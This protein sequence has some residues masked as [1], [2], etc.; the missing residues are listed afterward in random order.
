M[1]KNVP[2]LKEAIQMVLFW[3]RP[4]IAE[5]WARYTK[6]P[7]GIKGNLTTSSFGLDVYDNFL[8]TIENKYGGKKVHPVTNSY[9]FGEKNNDLPLRVIEVLE[10]KMTASQAINEFKQKAKF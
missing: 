2:H 3:C 6:C 5:Q 7:T 1:P 9:L 8:F 10:G 4:E